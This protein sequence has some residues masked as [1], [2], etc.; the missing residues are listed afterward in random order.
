MPA[1]TA[2][3]PTAAAIGTAAV[4]KLRRS[5]ETNSRLSSRPTMKKQIASRPSAAQAPKLSSRCQGSYPM[6]KSRSAK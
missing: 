2:T 3:P 1:G 5:P 4:R 6:R